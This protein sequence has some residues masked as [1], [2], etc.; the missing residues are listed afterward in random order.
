MPDMS[1]FAVVEAIE[2]TESPLIIFVTAHDQ[3]ALKAFEIH[4][5]DY[6]SKP[7]SKDRLHICVRRALK[8]I[9]NQK[10]QRFEQRVLSI[11]NKSRINE[12]HSLDCLRRIKV[13]TGSKIELV[14]VSAIDW[15]ESADQYTKL[16]TAEKSYL[17]HM[18]MWELEQKLNTGNFF[19]V[20]RCAVVNVKCVREVVIREHGDCFA[21][22]ENG[23]KVRVSRYRKNH[24]LDLLENIMPP[25]EALNETP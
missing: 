25:I 9:E 3:Y 23:T 16:H 10:R 4:A 17:V 15:M 6:L 5:L 1:A 21:I 13:R 20:H 24:F 22:L 18:G 12:R 8:Q 11:L 19:R 7:L 2:G 14:K